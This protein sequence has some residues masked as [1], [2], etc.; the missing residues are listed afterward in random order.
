MLLDDAKLNL[1]MARKCMDKKQLA[2]KAGI[3]MDTLKRG[4]FRKGTK[5]ST[6]GKIANALGVDPVEIVSDCSYDPGKEKEG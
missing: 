1:A 6:V 5:P 2:E 4:R 3:G